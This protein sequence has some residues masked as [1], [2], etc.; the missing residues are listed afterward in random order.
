M[1]EFDEHYAELDTLDIDAT[2]PENGTLPVGWLYM[3]HDVWKADVDSDADDLDSSHDWLLE[4]EEV[5]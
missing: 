3:G 1:F 5:A 2:Q 4:S